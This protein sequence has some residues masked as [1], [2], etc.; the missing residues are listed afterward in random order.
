[1]E[2]PS[3]NFKNLPV[4]RDQIHDQSSHNQAF[5]VHAFSASWINLFFFT[6]LLLFLFSCKEQIPE[7]Y[8]TNPGIDEFVK[9]KKAELADIAVDTLLKFDVSVQ[10]AIFSS[11]SPE[12]KSEAWRYRLSRVLSDNDFNLLEIIHIQRLIDSISPELFIKPNNYDNEYQAFKTEWLNYAVNELQWNEYFTA[13]LVYRFWFTQ[14]QF[15]NEISEYSVE[16]SEPNPVYCNCNSANDFCQE[17]HCFP[18]SCT[19]TEQG[20][21]WLWSQPCDG[22]CR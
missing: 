14:E 16:D 3:Y 20:C 5:I 15:T 7:Y 12:K 6:I 17:T 19:A 18:S 4:G 2:L 10:R 21:G 22:R 8:S 9:L 1:M 13:F 11:W